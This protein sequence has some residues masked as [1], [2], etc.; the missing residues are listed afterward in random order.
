MISVTRVFSASKL[1]RLP[2]P[3][4]DVRCPWCWPQAHSPHGYQADPRGS[5][6]R[7]PDV[8]LEAHRAA[9]QLPPPQLKGVPALPAHSVL[10]VP[11]CAKCCN[12]SVP[13]KMG[14]RGA[15]VP[16]RTRSEPRLP[17]LWNGHAGSPKGVKSGCPASP[18]LPRTC[19]VGARCPVYLQRLKEKAET[20]SHVWVSILE[21]TSP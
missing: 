20:S 11:C 12:T 10:T 17:D 19:G 3:M 8:Y 9:S 15:A 5:A 21:Q 13:R 14:H 7:G 6:R 4:P 18:P 2:L 16:G 1:C